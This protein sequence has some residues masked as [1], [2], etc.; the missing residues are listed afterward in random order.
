MFAFYV[1]PP[2]QRA[3]FHHCGLHRLDEVRPAE[4]SNCEPGFCTDQPADMSDHA[5]GN[6]SDQDRVHELSARTNQTPV[7]SSV[8][9]A[10]PMPAASVLEA[11][12]ISKQSELTMKSINFLTFAGT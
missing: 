2:T 12:P 5:L 9:N 8:A 7:V 6:R 10:L 3:A 4:G 1:R 11:A